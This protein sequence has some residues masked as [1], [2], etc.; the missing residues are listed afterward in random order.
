MVARPVTP[1]SHC[2]AIRPSSSIRAR[3][4]CRQA[5]GRRAGSAVRPTGRGGPGCRVDRALGEPWA[6]SGHNAPVP[7]R[8]GVAMAQPGGGAGLCGA[9]VPVLA[10]NRAPADASGRRRRG[11]GGDQVAA[12]RAGSVRALHQAGTGGC[13]GSGPMRVLGTVGRAPCT[14]LARGS[15]REFGPRAVDGLG[16]CRGR[17]PGRWLADGCSWWAGFLRWPGMGVGVRAPF[18]HQARWAWGPPAQHPRA[19]LPGPAGERGR[20]TMWRGGD[21]GPSGSGVPPMPMPCVLGSPK[22]PA[23]GLQ[24]CCPHSCG[25]ACVGGWG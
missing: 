22:A 25:G 11:R 2:P 23:I 18:T 21:N 14:C 7:H 1:S 6:E 4:P 10:G 24:I 8:G 19:R 9:A 17:A 12:V 13:W 15:G 5:T 16:C 20:A 3:L